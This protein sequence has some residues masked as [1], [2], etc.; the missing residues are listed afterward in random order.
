MNPSPVWTRDQLESSRILAEDHFRSSRYSEPRELYIALFDE[1]RG[2]VTEVLEQTDDLTSMEDHALSILSNSRQREVFRYLTG[3]PVS[4][5]DL[6]V[7]MG[8]TSISATRL[9]RDPKLL[10]DI[11]EFVK[12]WHDRRRFPWIGSNTVPDENSR[13]AA[14]LATSALLAMRRL[15]TM[16]RNEGKE[17]QERAVET[18]LSEYGFVQVAP[19]TIPTL[20]R[21]PAAGEFCRE[22][23]LGNRKADFVIGLFDSRTM[24]LECKVSNSSTNSV[25]RL[26]NDAA[27]KAE[28]WR[29][30]FG[31]LQVVT[32]AVLSGV[33]NNHNLEDAQNRGLTLFWAHDLDSM[34]EWLLSTKLE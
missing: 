29:S 13:A 31:T 23:M 20:Q 4:E 28:T 26:N 16:R 27:I 11:I 10:A 32:A 22:S 2:L 33:Y 7:L 19:R 9:S 21:A 30:D 14:I 5:D 24:A 6:K 8:R 34:I 12:D 25:K 1:Y 15:E 18:K 3:P 17:F